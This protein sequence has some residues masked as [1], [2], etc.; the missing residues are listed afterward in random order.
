[1]LDKNY[2]LELIDQALEGTGFYLVDLSVSRSNLVQVYL[3]HPDGLSLDDCARFS[4]ILNGQIDREE[5]DF[6]LQVSS[7]GLGQPIKV[8]RQYLKAV[9]QKLDLTL[10]SGDRIKG[11]LLEAREGV[12]GSEGILKILPAGTKRKPY[13]GDPIEIPLNEL[14]TARIEVDIK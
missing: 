7:P 14:V 10:T 5:E 11:T 4:S 12:P 13:T 3:D 6:E 9:G 8:F 2:I 1:M